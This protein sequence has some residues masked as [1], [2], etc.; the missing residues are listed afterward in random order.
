MTSIRD[1]TGHELSFLGKR[2][3][4]HG[5]SGVCF[6]YTGAE[7]VIFSKEIIRLQSQK[8]NRFDKSRSEERIARLIYYSVVSIMNLGLSCWEAEGLEGHVGGFIG[9][10]LIA[11]CL[12]L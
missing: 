2:F 8:Y 3:K 4:V 7:L 5:M 1:L 10:S 11:L 9:G 12:D 6:G